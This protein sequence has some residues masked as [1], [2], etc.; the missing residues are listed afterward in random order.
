MMGFLFVGTVV[1]AVRRD[2]SMRLFDQAVGLRGDAAQWRSSV[3]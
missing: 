3:V 1:A 2:W